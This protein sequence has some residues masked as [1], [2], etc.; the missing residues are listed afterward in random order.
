MEIQ[1]TPYAYSKMMYYLHKNNNEVSMFGISKKE[2]PSLVIDV[3][4]IKQEV[5]EV[6]TDMDD[7]ALADYVEDMVCKG[8]EPCEVLRIWIHSHPNFSTQPSNTDKETFSRAFKNASWKVMIII[9]K[10][11]ETYCLLRQSGTVCQTDVECEVTVNWNEGYGKDHNKVWDK[12]WNECVHVK[13]CFN[14]GYD[15][16]NNKSKQPKTVTEKTKSNKTDLMYN[17]ETLDNE[18]LYLMKQYIDDEINE[19][20]YKEGAAENW[21]LEDQYN[22]YLNL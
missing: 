9:S 22:E 19:R 16:L 4:L 5:G 8:Y 20:L 6:T 3:S 1:F 12:E 17:V 13:P 7:E 10:K 21:I 11:Y 15:D 14:Y 18:S 2:N